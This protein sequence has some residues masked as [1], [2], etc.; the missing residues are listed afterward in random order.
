MLQFKKILL[1][2]CLIGLAACGNGD[3]LDTTR[4][5]VTDTVPLDGATEVALNSAILVRFNEDIDPATITTTTFLLTDADDNAVAGSVEV[6][7]TNQIVV[8]TP[9]ENLASD[10]IYTAT[11]TEDIEDSDENNLENDLGWTFT[12]GV[13]TDVVAITI[14]SV[15]P[16]NGDTNVDRDDSVL[17]T[18]SESVNPMT[19]TS[20]SVTIEDADAA[21]VDVD[22][23]YD[24]ETATLTVDPTDD[25][26]N[27]AEYTVLVTTD[28]QDLAGN[29]LTTEATWSFTTDV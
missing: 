25:L 13:I 28:V 17:I 1:P 4:P 5:E 19:L 22:L 14:E 23:S 3:V 20:T 11:V 6:D 16:D 21:L 24:V 2:I 26:D 18:F 27:D 12:T 8:F 9:T 10:T 15:D 29:A 7:A